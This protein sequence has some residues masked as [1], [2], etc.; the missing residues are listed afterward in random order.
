MARRTSSKRRDVVRLLRSKPPVQKIERQGV[1]ARVQETPEWYAV[2]C[3][4]P[5][6]SKARS[7]APSSRGIAGA[8]TPPPLDPNAPRYLR[9]R[10]RGSNRLNGKYSK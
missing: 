5:S 4:S 2:T 8:A 9:P 3:T 10:E 7:S 1:A 6:K